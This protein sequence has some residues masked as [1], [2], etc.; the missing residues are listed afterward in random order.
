MKKYLFLSILA[1]VI[2]SS[3]TKQPV[4]HFQLD[5]HEVEVGESFT[6][7]NSSIDGV[8]YRWD[9]GNGDSKETTMND[10]AEFSYAYS[11]Y[12]GEE[13]VKF[14]TKTITLT[15]Y[16]KKEKESD[17]YTQTICLYHPTELAITVNEMIGV[18]GSPVANCEVVLYTDEEAFDTN[19]AAEIVAR[20]YTNSDG[21]VLISGLEEKEYFFKCQDGSLLT[22]LNGERKVMLRSHEVTSI[23]VIRL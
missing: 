17:V 18:I 7:S 12:D 2:F 10:D 21:L 14:V 1:V 23:S 9:L 3:C 22:T 5:R 6:I 15:A 19:N 20:G 8:I 11:K 16:S 4:A 13:D